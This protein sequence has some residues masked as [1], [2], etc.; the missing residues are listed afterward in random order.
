MSPDVV[1][2]KMA[3]MRSVL[4][5]LEIFES[6]S[7]EDF[8]KPKNHY[9]AERILQLLVEIASDIVQ[10]LLKKMNEEYPLTYRT[11]FLRAGE[12]GILSQDLSVRLAQ[13]AGMRNILVHL[14][15][16][17]DDR[18]VFKALKMLRNDFVQFLEEVEKQELEEN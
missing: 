5:D 15:E 3:A 4:N 18:R 16:T 11:V 6:M 10:H 17:I 14:Y 12:L 13:A 1:K 7:F 2:R 8:C 9:A